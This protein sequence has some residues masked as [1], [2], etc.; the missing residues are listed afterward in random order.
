MER[1]REDDYELIE[2]ELDERA[3]KRYREQQKRPRCLRC[4][5][6]MNWAEQKRQFGRLM[7][8]GF[9]VEE[10]K[11]TMPRCQKCMTAHL[12][13]TGRS[14]RAAPADRLV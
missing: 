13:E 4:Q 9:T 3:E 8:I 6:P 1:G 10:A 5:R 7:S 14:T 11:Q 12:R 2:E